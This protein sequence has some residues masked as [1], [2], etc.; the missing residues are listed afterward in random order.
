VPPGPFW[1]P[2]G[3]NIGFATLG[4]AVKKIAVSG[5]AP[6]TIT[7]STS[8]FGG[9]AWNRDGDILIG[10]PRGVQRISG[11]AVSLITHTDESKETAHAFPQF[12]PD[13]NHFIYLAGGAI[14]LSS[15]SGNTA[16]RLIESPSRAVYAPPLESGHLGHLL[17]VRE[18]SLMAQPLDSNTFHPVGDAFPVEEQV[19]TAFGDLLG[20][21]S[22]SPSG[23]LAYRVG[24]G[25]GAH[26]LT[27]FDREGRPLGTVGP[28][29]RYADVAV[30]RDGMQIVVG[31]DGQYAAPHLWLINTTD[32]VPNLLTSSSGNDAS[33]VWSPD[34]R[35]LAFSSDRDRVYGEF[36]AYVKDLNGT[37]KEEKIL[38]TAR[39][40]DWSRDGKY[41][42]YNARAQGGVQLWY[43]PVDGERKPVPFPHA[44]RSNEAQGQF[45]PNPEG[46][47]TPPRWIAYTSNETGENEIYVQ[48]FPP[49]GARPV[50]ISSDGGMSPR[51]R[52]DGRELFYISRDDRLIAVDIKAG[53]TVEHGPPRELFK[54]RIRSRGRDAYAFNYDVSPDGKRFLIVSRPASADGASPPMS[55]VTN[56]LAGVKK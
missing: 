21:F 25:V 41:L 46:A 45:A 5:G 35:R 34:G 8:G 6:V 52:A 49:G 27:W 3:R 50:R 56:W 13:G 4:G 28:A 24:S 10:S 19:G 51:W 55:V 53:L 7:D 11:G 18:S 38:N 23:A 2:D 1:S 33:P 30:S 47:G 12:L 32:G 54:A 37:G 15:L 48:S 17:Y 42:L 39:M 26:Q 31:Q 14:Y 44:P 40:R 36:N 20:F 22:V 16:E 29:G 43:A 9:G